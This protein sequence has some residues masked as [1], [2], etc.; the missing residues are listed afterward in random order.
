MC[1]SSD[2]TSSSYPSDTTTC[3][4]LCDGEVKYCLVQDMG[5]HWSGC[6]TLDADGK[7]PQMYD[8]RY[9]NDVDATDYF[10]AFFDRVSSK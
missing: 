9:A 5:H 6:S 3:N 8:P 1:G 2:I 10:A 4:Q 7:Q